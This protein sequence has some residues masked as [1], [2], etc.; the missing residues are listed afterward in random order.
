MRHC[1]VGPV[2]PKFQM[3]VVPSFLRASC[4]LDL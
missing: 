3:S 2:V 4:S 1:I